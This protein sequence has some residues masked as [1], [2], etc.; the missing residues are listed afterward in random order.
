MRYRFGPYQFDARNASLEGP[1]G[2]I[3]LRPMTLKLLHA[4]LDAA[5]DLIAHE[6]L[7]DQVW[8]RQAVTPGVLS[9]SIRELRR[10]L[11][12]SAQGSAWIETRHKLGYRF[13]GEVERWA[14]DDGPPDGDTTPVAIEESIVPAQPAPSPT[15][16]TRNVAPWVI[17]AIVSATL[18]AAFFLL[19]P[20]ASP[21]SPR[22]HTVEVIHDGRPREP[23]ALRWYRGGLDA[24]AAYDPT[25][26]QERFERAL[27]REPSSIAALA[28]LAQALTQRGEGRRARELIEPLRDGAAA[29]PREAQLQI[30]AFL[31][32]LEHRHDDALRHLTALAGLNPG[33]AEA[34]LRLAAMQIES[35]RSAEAGATLERL[36]M[37]P[38]I[39]HARLA[40][41]RARLAAT[42]GDQPMRLAEATRA[43]DAATATP[44]IADALLEQGWAQLLTGNTAA[45]IALKDRLHAQLDAADWPA[46]RIRADLFAAT[47]QREAGQLDEAIAGFEHSAAAARDLGLP[48]LDTLARRE[49]A[50]VRFIAGRYDEA[51]AALAELEREQATLGDPRALAATLGVA[52][53]VENRRGHADAAQTLAERALSSH[54]DADDATGEAAARI[55]LGTLYQR[56]GR[57]EEAHQQWESARALF[58]R[59]GNRRGEATA[60]GNLAITHGQAGRSVAARE[61]QED[62]LA[63]FREIG[64]TPDIARTQFNLGIQDRRA[65][66][67][68][69]AQARIGEALDGFTAIGAEAF[70]LQA[71]ATLAELHLMRADPDSALMLLADLDPA[72]LA[73]PERAGA[74]ASAQ[75]RLAML[76]GDMESAAAG[77]DQARDLRQRASLAD[78]A[79]MSELDLAELAARRGDLPAAERLVRD[80]RRNMLQAGDTNAA[81]QAGILLAAIRHARGDHA[82][83]DRLLDELESELAARP[84]AYLALRLDLVRAAQDLPARQTALR[85]LATRAR[86][87]G[88]EW[89]AL[90]AELI[91]GDE[92]SARNALL[93]L[94][95]AAEGMPPALPY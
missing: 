30:A 60:L 44:L 87:G 20:A 94:G 72:T 86:N 50:Y 38:R 28:G 27:Q 33:D 47:L 8:G 88:F 66:K 24:L 22:G 70:R 4:L 32:Q 92:T 29:L 45:A 3:P 1:H 84:D 55:T 59:L 40:L 37:L 83:A 14:D 17:A 10:A 53:Q 85:N 23:E 21:V 68:A 5:P 12:D 62:A 90:R 67:L 74:I 63:I 6:R 7:L 34:G 48:A 93:R 9:Q 56:T 65:G 75:A 25:G 18:A 51:A 36:A 49:A 69:E 71:I 57:H 13:A 31:A 61:H 15:A 42:R 39:D 76:R 80:L 73:P 91:G 78:W 16:R 82:G 77:F 89:L 2:L 52:A 64:A 54:I 19:R 11:G 81:L 43:A 46:A 35:G 26:A 41:L 58:V 79:L 95:L